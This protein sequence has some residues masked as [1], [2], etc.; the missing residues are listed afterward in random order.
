MN[1]DWSVGKLLATSS[2]YWRG[3]SLQAGVRLGVFTALHEG[4]PASLPRAQ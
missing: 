2:A 4:P 1:R 3:C